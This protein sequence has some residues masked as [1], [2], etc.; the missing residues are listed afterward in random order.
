MD[1]RAGEAATGI[2]SSGVQE[3]LGWERPR[4]CCLRMSR[5][6]GPNL[7]R[8]SRTQVQEKPI[9]SKVRSHPSHDKPIR[10]E[11]QGPEVDR[12]R[13]IARKEIGCM[14]FRVTRPNRD[15]Q[16]MTHGD[17]TSM[18]RRFATWDVAASRRGHAESS[19]KGSPVRT[20]SACL[21]KDQTVYVRKMD[22]VGQKRRLA[23]ALGCRSKVRMV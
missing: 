5:L 12:T 10:L 15:W 9:V 21:A 22:L 8:V 1:D 7:R 11:Q 13:C 20:V 19:F 14:L 17:W 3:F 4:S 18:R 2:D 23:M 6:K 16:K